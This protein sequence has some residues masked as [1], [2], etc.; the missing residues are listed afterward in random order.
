MGLN[1]KTKMETSYLSLGSNI[2]GR[3]RLLR[4]AVRQLNAHHDI[5]VTKISSVYE[6]EAWGLENQDDFYNVALQIKTNLG[7]YELLDVCQIIEQEFGRSREIHWGPRTI[8]IDILLYGRLDI[9]EEKLTV[10]H[11]YMLE[12][13]FVIV[14]LN[15]I[16]PNLTVSGIM[17]SDIVKKFCQNSTCNKTQH[18][19]E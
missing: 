3:L 10:P 1:M 17:I 15:E 8:D 13:E 12:R 18:E 6:T 7:P 2:G 14:P 16:A 19:I 11:Q 9:K 4:K 5:T